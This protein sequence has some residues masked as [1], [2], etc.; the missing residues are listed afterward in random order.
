MIISKLILMC[1]SR[2]RL[3]ANFIVAAAVVV[4]HS[5]LQGIIRCVS[6][7]R[8]NG[9]RS[10]VFF[11]RFAFWR[12]AQ[13]KFNESSSFRKLVFSFN[14][15]GFLEKSKRASER[16][17]ERER[18]YVHFAVIPCKSG[19]RGGVEWGEFWGE[20]YEPLAKAKICSRDHPLDWDWWEGWKR[21]GRGGG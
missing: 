7:S 3:W 14:F 19:V 8:S 6:I 5:A 16:A 10:Q 12:I 13:V 11:A 15:F 9:E 2:E 17:R 21:S 4:A 1:S 20:L 18:V